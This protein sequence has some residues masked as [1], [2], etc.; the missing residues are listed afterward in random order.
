M[1]KEITIIDIQSKIVSLLG[2]PDAI[3]AQDLAELYEITTEDINNAVSSND[4]LFPECFMFQATN[5]ETEKLVFHFGIPK[6]SITKSNP[7][8]FTQSGANMLSG[9]LKSDVAIKRSIQIIRAFTEKPKDLTRL[10][11]LQMA[12]DSEKEKI[13][14]IKERDEAIRTKACISDKKTATAMQTASAKSRK[15]NIEIRKRLELEK[16]L[17]YENANYFFAVR[18]VIWLEDFFCVLSDEFFEDFEQE[19]KGRSV[20]M[21][22]PRQRLIRGYDEQVWGYHSKVI[23][24]LENSLLKFPELLT[25]YRFEFAA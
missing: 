6:Q 15:A 11:I 1:T 23:D 10:D 5:D 2:R 14:A 12:I 18:D 19:L 16:N 20:A 24:S 9:I 17:G 25:E 8:L 21:G 7:Y 13:I 3:L 4:E 22:I